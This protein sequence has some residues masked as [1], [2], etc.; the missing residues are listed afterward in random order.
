MLN[1]FFNKLTVTNKSFLEEL[2]KSKLDYTILDKIIKNK[3]ID[4]NY[5]D[6]NK[7][8]FLHLCINSKKY[9]ASKWL[10]QNNI[11]VRLK[12]NH[13][14][15]AI[16]IA[17]ERNDHYSFELLC[18]SN[19][20][21]LNILDSQKRT[22]LQNAVISGQIRII[23]ILLQYDIDVNNLDVNNR[24]VLFDAISFGD[25]NL[26]KIIINIPNL[27]FNVVDIHGHTILHKKAVLDDDN[28]ATLLLEKGS[29]PTICNFK[30]RVYW[31]Q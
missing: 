17:L 10:I 30:G 12:N 9:N 24:N 6:K 7:N 29:D 23:K 16:D 20:I 28:L 25:D 18:K 13:D 2:Y 15:E 22:L 1:S 27:N 11:N 19:N 14:D 26:T 21:N 8:S 4:I 5:Q 3:S 31:A